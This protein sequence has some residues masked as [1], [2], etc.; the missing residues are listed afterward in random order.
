MKESSK[1]AVLGITLT[2]LGGI[3]WGFSGSCGQYLFTNCGVTP[4][5]L[6]PIRMISTGAILLGGA[7]VKTKIKYLTFGETGAEPCVCLHS[8]SS[9]L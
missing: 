6:V 7:A 2:L 4:R 5:W 8:R 3:F 1:S 9:G